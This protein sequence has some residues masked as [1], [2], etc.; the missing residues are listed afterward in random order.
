[1]LR[2]V[3]T[4]LTQPKTCKT[5]RNPSNYF[6]FDSLNFLAQGSIVGL[7][8]LLVIFTFRLACQNYVVIQLFN[9]YSANVDNMASSYQC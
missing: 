5:S 2:D 6:L 1:M 9:S 8:C 3:P 4:K 7:N